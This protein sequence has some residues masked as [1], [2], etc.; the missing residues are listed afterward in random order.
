MGRMFFFHKSNSG[1]IARR[2]LKQVLV[3][4][5][6]GCSPGL[7]EGIREE[8]IGVLSR[9]MELDSG[10]MDI[11][12]TWMECVGTRT[13]MAALTAKIP[14]RSFTNM[15]NESCFLKKKKKTT[16]IV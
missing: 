4:D 3:S 11:G 12:L 15:R 7:I 5:Q 2:R 14:I 6:S 9:Y 16:T 1:E 10:K 13:P 8:L